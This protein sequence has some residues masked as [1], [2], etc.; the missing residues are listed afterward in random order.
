MS[1]PDEHIGFMISDVAR[2]MRTVFDRRVRRL[3]LTRAQWLAL[4]RLHRRPGA[5]Q[6]ELADMMEVEKATV[7]RLIDR[8][9]AKGWVERRAQAGDR[10][11]NRVYLTAE[12][13]RLHMRIW[14]IAEAT[15]EDALAELSRRE[16]AQL[17]KLLGRVK[18]RLVDMADAPVP[19]L[20]AKDA[21]LEAIGFNAKVAARHAGSEDEV[22]AP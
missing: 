14:R 10:R 19:Q 5:S 7:G 20:A 3:G 22:V 15:V 18:S 9:E 12:A 13:E 17:R 6:S 11:V 16:A 2:L 21:D 8:L 4:T 1:N